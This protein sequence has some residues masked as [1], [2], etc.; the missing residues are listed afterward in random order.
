[1][2]QAN[3]GPYLQLLLAWKGLPSSKDPEKDLS[4][5]LVEAHESDILLFRSLLA[6]KLNPRESEPLA[7]DGIVRVIT[8]DLEQLSHR[9]LS[10]EDNPRPLIGHLSDIH[11]QVRKA[12]AATEAAHT[13]SIQRQIEGISPK[14]KDDRSPGE[15]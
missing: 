5:R 10:F 14:R 2:T 3:R 6:L 15:S 9:Y 11:Q 4:L 8:D 7:V 12:L 13:A 1:M